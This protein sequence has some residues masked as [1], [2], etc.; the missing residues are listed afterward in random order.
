MGDAFKWPRIYAMNKDRV[1]DD[2]SQLSDP[3]VLMPGWRLSV[4]VAQ[5]STSPPTRARLPTDRVPDAASPNAVKRDQPTRHPD[6]D[7]EHRGPR[8]RHSTRAGRQMREEEAEAGTETPTVRKGPAAI[9]LGEAGLIGITTAAGLLAARRYWYRHKGRLSEIR[10]QEAPALSPL[11]DKAVQAANAAARTAGAEGRDGL[12]TGTVQRQAPSTPGTVTIGV[13][14]GVEVGLVELAIPGGCAWTGPGAESAARALL[15]GVLTAAERRSP[16]ASPVKAIVPAEVAHT[17][18]PGLPRQ[19][20]VLTQADGL[21]QALRVAEQHLVDH[22]R[23]LDER[24]AA[25]PQAKALA[26]DF[27]PEA[28]GPGVLLLMAVPDAT[29]R[30]QLQAL[31]ARSHPESLIVLTMGLSLPEAQTWHVADDGVVHLGRSG[32]HGG[33]LALFHLTPDAGRDVTAV[34]LAAHGQSRRSDNPFSVDR[35]PTAKVPIGKP[36][37]VPACDVTVDTNSFALPRTPPTQTRPVRLHVLGPITLYARPHQDPVGTHLRAEVHEFLALL[38]AHPAGLL[39]S[40]IADKL[41]LDPQGG[42]NELKN[43][44]RAVR[45]TLRAATGVAGQ[46]FVLLQGE[47]HKLHPD[48][49]ETDLTDFNQALERAVSVP[50]AK[51]AGDVPDDVLLAVGEALNH[52]RGPFAQGGDYLWADAIREHLAMR[53][54]DAVLRVARQSEPGEA[55]QPS[56]DAVLTML[57]HLCGIHP[58]RERLAQQAIRLYQAAGR[59][60]A[61]RHSYSRLKRCL[62]ELDLEPEPATQALM[63]L[64]GHTS[65][66]T[67]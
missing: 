7:V 36:S 57:E 27:K 19:F 29:Y 12:T 63:R 5:A 32:Q 8:A 50:D 66:A 17:L 20:S 53:A 67:S 21:E 45:R 58:D 4:S 11:V 54:S 48:L 51:T 42:Q 9:S 37:A 24:D 46:E 3:D 18:L 52:Y 60:D 25:L 6:N 65:Q 28:A 15:V 33:S 61:A 35:D 26:A 59:H 40:E 30:G 47:L 34:L 31:A 39:A 64:R 16:G 49:V 41:N 56:R 10:Q 23:T 43:L 2:G 1:Q 55:Q 38:A 14:D 62:A 13:R 44:R 22:A